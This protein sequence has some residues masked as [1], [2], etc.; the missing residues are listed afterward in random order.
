MTIEGSRLLN[1]NY[2]ELPM[3]LTGDFNVNFRSQESQPLIDFLE[4]KFDL[5]MNTSR[6]HSTTRFGTTID[7]VFSRKVANL[8]SKIYV[9]HYSYH[10]PIISYVRNYDDIQLPVSNE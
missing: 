8:E 1:S 3:I 5:S 2:H 6:L 9:S 4:E 7:A 10:K